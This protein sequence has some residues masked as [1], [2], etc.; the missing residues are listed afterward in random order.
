MKRRRDDSVALIFGAR[1]I[2][3]S[4]FS[5]FFSD[6]SSLLIFFPLSFGF[7]GKDGVMIGLGI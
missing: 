1:Y 5:P 6:S 7:L 2:T 3:F 4:F